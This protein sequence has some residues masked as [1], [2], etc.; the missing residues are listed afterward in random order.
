MLYFFQ[1]YLG[2]VASPFERA[3]LVGSINL[4]GG[5]TL[6]GLVIVVVWMVRKPVR[7]LLLSGNPPGLARRTFAGIW[8][9]V[10]TVVVA[11]LTLI[12]LFAAV[13]LGHQGVLL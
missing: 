9:V 13:G 10:G 3:V 8:S 11:L 7:A 4:V 1:A 5:L 2:A 12:G 6:M